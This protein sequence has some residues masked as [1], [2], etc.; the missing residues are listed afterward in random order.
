MTL[1]HH[2]VI[3]LALLLLLPPV[4]PAEA[5]GGVQKV[6]RDEVAE[7]V[8]AQI[9]VLMEQWRAERAA[10]REAWAAERESFM[11]L[12]QL[13]FQPRDAIEAAATGAAEALGEA[14]VTEAGKAARELVEKMPIDEVR[15]I[16]KD[17]PKEVVDRLKDQLDEQAE[18][19]KALAEEKQDALAAALRD[20][21]GKDFLGKEI[22]IDDWS[23][24]DLKRAVGSLST[25]AG[26]S[27][28]EMPDG[29]A[30]DA[31]KRLILSLSDDGRWTSHL[32]AW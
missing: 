1:R 29:G 22:Q 12:I 8:A 18:K 14:A 17:T 21:C 19:L 24:A 6:I 25:V 11:S 2:L 30:T 10:D 9:A 26:L 15:E 27:E 32:L 3:F 23:D 13:A 16:A 31:I 20:A 4:R 7:Q 5:Q 28:I